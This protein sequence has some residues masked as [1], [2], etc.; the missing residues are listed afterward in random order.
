MQ[1]I[2]L[3]FSG[4][5]IKAFAHIGALK[6]FEEK[7]IKFDMVAGTS[8]GSI[9]ATLYALG[10]KSDAMNEILRRY[11]RKLRY[12]DKKILFKIIFGLIFTG[13]IV[14]D[15]LNSGNLITKA[16]KDICRENKIENI[17]QIKM[18]LVIPAVN[19]QNG[20]VIVF[21]SK[22]VR[23]RISDEVKYVMDAPVDLAVRS[24]C[25]YPG[26]FSPCIY[27]NYQLVDG[28]VRENTAWKELKQIGADKVL[29]IN[30]STD[31]N[32]VYY[33]NNM[34]EVAI[35]SMNLMNHELANYELLGIDD[36]LTITTKK[37]GLLDKKQ[38]DYL[39][40]KGYKSA[41]KYIDEK[42]KKW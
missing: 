40:E 8:S 35:R 11:I 29:G 17:N 18:P 39:Y 31:E 41:K 28:G 15:G 10:Y 32:K 7:N 30:F 9:I 37:I 3:C 12:I 33:C 36:L 5:G 27:K 20:E 14:V 2:G 13:K 4:G 19:L 38:I 24:S 25:G 21:T 6:A 22:E 42:V 16:I 26:V 23:K 34:I 1:K